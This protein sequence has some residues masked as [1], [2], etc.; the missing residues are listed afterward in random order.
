MVN[1]VFLLGNLGR[2]PEI[3]YLP[4][5]NQVTNF[6]LATSEKREGKEYTE[7]HRI[8]A[9]GKLAEICGEHLIKGTK[10]WVEGRIHYESWEKEGEKRSATKIIIHQ[11]KILSGGHWDE[12]NQGDPEGPDEE[13]PF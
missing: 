11:L 1:R 2:D 13:V 10:V 5:G 9:F 6:S 4:N 3:K 7:W 12:K 8:T